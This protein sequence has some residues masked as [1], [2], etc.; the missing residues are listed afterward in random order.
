MASIEASEETDIESL[1]QV[2]NVREGSLSR[3]H[4]ALRRDMEGGYPFVINE[5]DHIRPGQITKL[6]QILESG[7]YMWVI[8]YTVIVGADPVE[9]KTTGYINVL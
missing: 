3:S 2:I 7:T 9:R 4:G 1:I 8:E 6:F 5:W